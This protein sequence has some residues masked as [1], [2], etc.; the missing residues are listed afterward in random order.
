MTGEKGKLELQRRT[1]S[2]NRTKICI[3]LF[4][5]IILVL[6][7]KE[8]PKIHTQMRIK[9]VFTLVIRDGLGGFAVLEV[10]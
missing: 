4:T 6:V 9:R 5:L 1:H 8:T 7:F 3:I 10:Y 2:V